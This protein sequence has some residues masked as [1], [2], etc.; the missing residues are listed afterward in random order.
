MSKRQPDLFET[1][2]DP[3][4]EPEAIQSGL[5]L[6]VPFS[7]SRALVKLDLER[8]EAN[9]REPRDLTLDGRDEQDT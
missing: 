6:A 9:R 5:G 1:P 7:K 4:D 2:T 3:G 8:A